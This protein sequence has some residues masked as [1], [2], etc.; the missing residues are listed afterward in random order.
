MDWTDSGPLALGMVDSV[1]RLARACTVQLSDRVGAQLGTGFIIE[2]KHI[3]PSA[4][5]RDEAVLITCAHV[6]SGRGGRLAG[7]SPP[8]HPEAARA[9]RSDGAE[10]PLGEILWEGER[11]SFF[12]V[13]IIRFAEGSA[14]Q[15]PKPEEPR[16]EL[17]DWRLEDLEEGA[18]VFLTGY[19]G[20]RNLS[21]SYHPENERLGLPNQKEGEAV[22]FRYYIENAPGYSGSP[23][24]CFR[25][26]NIGVI[27]IHARG[28]VREPGAFGK[29]QLPEG[30]AIWMQSIID[31]VRRRC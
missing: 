20:G 28:S 22:R 13:A 31:A 17:F 10:M 30:E 6:I 7:S 14:R 4:P 21:L 5:W 9:K 8:L 16:L 25:D 19:P 27:G 18:R 26:S 1:V 12:D 3:D 15:P 24:L 29:L 23:V 11:N 2:G